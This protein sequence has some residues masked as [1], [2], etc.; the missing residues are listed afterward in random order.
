ME[1]PVLHPAFSYTEA[2][3][4][5]E[6]KL[7]FLAIE[8]TICLG[9]PNYDVWTEHGIPQYQSVKVGFHFR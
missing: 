9:K 6:T 5:M 2:V 7:H 3:I 1:D 8:T 4:F